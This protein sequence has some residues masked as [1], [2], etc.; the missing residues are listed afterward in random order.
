MYAGAWHGYWSGPIRQLAPTIALIIAVTGAWLMG[1]E[2]GHW[3]LHGSFVPWLMRGLVGMLLLGSVFWLIAFA[4]LWRIGRNKF[5]NPTGES[6]NPVLGAVVGCWTGLLWSIVGFLLLSAVG[7]IAQFWLENTGNAPPSFGRR[8]LNKLVVVKNSLALVNGAAWLE[9]WNPLP[10]HTHK[11]IEKG[12]RV[13][14][15]PGAM[16]R[17]Q[18]LQQIRGIATH[19][20]FYPLTQDPE[21]RALIVQR[22]VEKLV[23]HPAVWQLLS[24]DEF[25]Q[26][27]ASTDLEKLFDEALAGANTTA[28]PPAPAQIQPAAALPAP[29]PEPNTQ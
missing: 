7:A 9:T 11:L 10:H 12:L 25:Q 5:P 21:I 24:D 2:F 3:I 1:P 17:L 29:P 15:T 13:L 27:V 8:A 23:S 20:S 6:E 4:V 19:P 14:N 18:N 26:L 28:Q 22:N 16:S